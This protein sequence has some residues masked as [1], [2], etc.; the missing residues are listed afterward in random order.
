MDKGTLDVVFYRDEHQLV[1]Y[2][3][4]IRRLY[5]DLLTNNDPIRWLDVGAGFG[6]IIEVLRK[7][8]PNNS[9]VHGIEPMRA[10]AKVAR[11]RGVSILPNTL[12]EVAEKYQ[13]ISLINVFSH[14]PNPRSFLDEVVDRL[15]PGGEILIETGNGGDLK[16]ARHY[17]GPLYLPDHLQFAGECHLKRFLSDVGLQII[18]KR[19][20]RTDTARLAIHCI[21]QKFRGQKTRIRVPYTSSF[22]TVFYRARACPHDR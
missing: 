6:E 16:S 11:E 22:R 20:M 7:I 9:I 14:L 17:L 3:K 2:E 12:S 18:S 1:F 19:R 5:V 13:V 15:S 10:K 8:L 21:M 4:I